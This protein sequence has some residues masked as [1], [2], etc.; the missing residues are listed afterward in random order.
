M[1]EFT[2]NNTKNASTSYILFK[3]NYSYYL[4][5]LYKKDIKSYFQSESV[6][7]L[8]AKLPK[9]IIAYEK[10]LYYG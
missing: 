9:L 6:Y 8:L 4:C 1:F 3:L 10:N 7:K 5:V 2:Y